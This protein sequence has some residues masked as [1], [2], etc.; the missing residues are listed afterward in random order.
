MTEDEIKRLASTVASEAAQAAVI[1]ATD[2]AA[3]IAAEVASKE[4]LKLLV[5][6]VVDE[7]LE[8]FGF[9]TGQPLQMQQNIAFLQSWRES[10]SAIKRQAWFVVIGVGLVGVLGLVWAAVKGPP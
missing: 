5:K 9:D 10:S 7:T 1:R 6:E 3:K 2:I 8:R 4:A